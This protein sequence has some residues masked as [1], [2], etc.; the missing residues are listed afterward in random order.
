MKKLLLVIAVLAMT[1]CK[2][3]PATT[4]PGSGSSATPVEATGSAGSASDAKADG[5]AGGN[6]P[7]PCAGP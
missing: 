7:D 5:S 1:A 6:T 3:K 2:H 4:T